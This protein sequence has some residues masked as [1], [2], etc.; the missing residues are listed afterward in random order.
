MF[1]LLTKEDQAKLEKVFEG[2]ADKAER[3][4]EALESIA[5]S[6]RSIATA[7]QSLAE[8]HGAK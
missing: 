1:P 6:Q 3:V 5:E 8:R 7:L 2:A 4:V